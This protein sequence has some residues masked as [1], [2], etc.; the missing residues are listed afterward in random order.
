MCKV[1]YVSSRFSAAIA[2]AIT[3]SLGGCSSNGNA[4]YMQLF[5]Y[6]QQS[7]SQK[8][9]SVPLDQASAIPYASLGIRISGGPEQMLVL[10]AQNGSDLTWTAA[11]HILVTTRQGRIVSS[12]G[13]GHDISALTSLDAGDLSSPGLNISTARSENLVADFATLKLYSVPI[14]CTIAPVGPET[15]SILG[16]EIRTLRVDEACSAPQLHWSYVNSY[17]VDADTKFVWRSSQTLSPDADPIELEMLR[18]PS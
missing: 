10:A 5:H 2:T 15:I 16:S 3:L 9:S 11:S 12:F 6:V 1:P 13:L 4:D 18:P 14:V 7:W 17:W 8:R